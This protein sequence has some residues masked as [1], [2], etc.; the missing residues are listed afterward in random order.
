M[1]LLISVG[2]QPLP[3][4]ICEFTGGYP[5][6][7]S[8][9]SRVPQTGRPGG[10]ILQ[11]LPP[12]I[13]HAETV[14][15][16]PPTEHTVT[17]VN[18]NKVFTYTYNLDV[19]PNCYCHILL[20]KNVLSPFRNEIRRAFLSCLDLESRINQKIKLHSLTLQQTKH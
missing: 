8:D 14:S 17:H 12:W 11:L 7:P 6:M 4:H 5:Q 20:Y 3:L 2:K 19:S 16:P 13:P 15:A 1:A 18:R 10:E 9:C